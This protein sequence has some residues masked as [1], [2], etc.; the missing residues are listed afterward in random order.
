L[1]RVRKHGICLDAQMGFTRGPNTVWNALMEIVP[2]GRNACTLVYRPD[3][4]HESAAIGQISHHAGDPHARV[5]FV[6]PARA[7][8]SP[9]SIHLLDAL[10][11]AVGRSKACVVPASPSSLGSGSG[12]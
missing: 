5:S 6:G 4:K 12:A 2:T 1:H 11:E 9:N 7:L 3:A 8:S 10:V